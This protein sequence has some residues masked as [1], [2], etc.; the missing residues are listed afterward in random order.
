MFIPSGLMSTSAYLRFKRTG[1][2][3]EIF[4]ATKFGADNT[5]PHG[6]NGTPEGARTCLNESL[7]RLGVEAID[8][9]YL[10]RLVII[11]RQNAV[12]VHPIVGQTLQCRS[13]CA[14]NLR[15]RCSFFNL[16]TGICWSYGWVCRV[17]RDVFL[18]YPYDFLLLF[19]EGKV[20]YLGLCECSATTLRRAHAVHPIA[21]VQVEYSPFTLDIEDPKVNLLKTARELGVKIVAYSPLGRGLLTGQFVR[22]LFQWKR[23]RTLK[24]TWQKSPDDFGEDDFRRNIPR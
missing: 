7:E 19:R 17:S 24:G 23:S 21:A 11:P 18:L 22:L 14:Y 8:L 1:K 15:W 16:T 6:I 4:L 3:H 13:R 5:R 2:R 12:D 20:R 10:H 9:Y